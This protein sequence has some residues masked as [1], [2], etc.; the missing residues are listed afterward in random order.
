MRDKIE[1][2]LI[3]LYGETDEGEIDEIESL[4]EEYQRHAREE[5]LNVFREVEKKRWKDAKHCSCMRHA[6]DK[7]EKKM[8]K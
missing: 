7:A 6:I 8:V 2:V 3:H 4:I 1:K 5:V